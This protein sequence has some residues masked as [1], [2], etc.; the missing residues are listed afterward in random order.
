VK[1]E[2]GEKAEK[3]LEAMVLT[4]K[5]LHL[6]LRIY[7]KNNYNHHLPEKLKRMD[8]ILSL[9]NKYENGTLHKKTWA[10]S[11]QSR[12]MKRFFDEDFYEVSKFGVFTADF[13]C[14][15]SWYNIIVKDLDGNILKTIRV[16][17]DVLPL[18]KQNAVRNNGFEVGSGLSERNKHLKF[19]VGSALLF[20]DTTQEHLTSFAN[21]MDDILAC[22]MNELR[23]QTGTILNEFQKVRS[24]ERTFTREL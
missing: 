17:D 2:Y 12:N 14:F 6:L 4:E 13:F 3:Q 19:E 10:E 9:M 5:L 18:L 1:R 22:T 8:R 16:I 20:G 23:N 11:M 21:F 15:Q 24:S 7:D